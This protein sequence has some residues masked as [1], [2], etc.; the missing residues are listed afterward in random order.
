MEGCRR[1]RDR[2]S[3]QAEAAK[4][5]DGKVK[6][7]KRCWWEDSQATGPNS[8]P[9]PCSPER[10]ET[11]REQ[12]IHPQRQVWPKAKRNN[13]AA[14]ARVTVQPTP[15]PTMIVKPRAAV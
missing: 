15:P 7:T 9:A 3:G 13:G 12:V 8:R 5:L 6:Q 4:P 2:R 14:S 1:C 11:P 10:R